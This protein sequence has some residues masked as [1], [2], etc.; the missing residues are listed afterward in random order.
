MT[1]TA[2]NKQKSEALAA[3]RAAA[4]LAGVDLA[5]RCANLGLAPPDANGSLRVRVFGKALLL[6]PPGFSATDIATGAPARPADCILALHYLLC[7]LPVEPTGRWI[8]FRDFPGGQF[9]WGPF[10]A[11]TTNALVARI[12]NDLDRLR[13]NLNRF[14]SRPLDL[15]DLSARIQAVGVVDVALIY[16]RGDEEMP[17]TAELLFDGCA[18]RCFS[19]EDASVLA[20]RVC[21][22]LL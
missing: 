9:Y 4:A 2:T 21:L 13:Q 7:S 6:S 14:E 17:P 15:P 16:R 12:G 11:R 19:A 8:S 20:S 1:Q 22:G 18:K 5:A 3:E 10:S